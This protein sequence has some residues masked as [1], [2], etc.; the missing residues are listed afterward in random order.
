MIIG[1]NASLFTLDMFS[2]K[3]NKKWEVGCGGYV[4]GKP[5]LEHYRE[6]KG[7]CLVLKKLHHAYVPTNF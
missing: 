1:G 6:G 3:K 7:H 4:G 2:K 5:A